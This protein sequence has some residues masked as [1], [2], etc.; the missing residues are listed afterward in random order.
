MGKKVV[1]ETP[2]RAALLETVSNIYFQLVSEAFQMSFKDPFKEALE[3][4]ARLRR[5]SEEQYRKEV[6]K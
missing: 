2:D 6:E 5:T 3:R 1:S 4:E